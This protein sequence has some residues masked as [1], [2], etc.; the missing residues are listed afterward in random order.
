M[1]RHKHKN[2]MLR[3]F[4]FNSIPFPK[5]NWT[6]ASDQDLLCGWGTTSRS[7]A[8]NK[9]LYTIWDVHDASMEESN[10]F[11]AFQAAAMRLLPL[12]LH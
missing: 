9:R 12:F 6:G 4:Q 1:L 11:A 8:S 7:Y 2:K 5:G 10:A 3:F